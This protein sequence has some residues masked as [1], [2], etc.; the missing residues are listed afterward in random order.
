MRNEEKT[1]EEVTLLWITN[2]GL[3]FDVAV[4]DP[5]QDRGHN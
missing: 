3:E 4:P 1:W 5:L 2:Q